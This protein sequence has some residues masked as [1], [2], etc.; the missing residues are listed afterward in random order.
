[1]PKASEHKTVQARNLKYAEEFGWT[2][3]PHEDVPLGERAVF[4][5]ARVMT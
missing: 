1:M 5:W 2:F 4:G 3:V